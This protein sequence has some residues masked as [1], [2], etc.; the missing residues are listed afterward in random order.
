M[1]AKNFILITFLTLVFFFTARIIG[2][3]FISKTNFWQI[4][5][6][7]NLHHYHLGFALIFI[8]LIFLNKLQEIKDYFLAIGFGM[9][10]DE[11][12][13][14]FK[15]LN[16]GIF[17]HYW[18]SFTSIKFILGTLAQLFVFLIYSFIIIKQKNKNFDKNSRSLIQ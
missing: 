5:I 17:S 9:I 7:D 8:A 18:G 4:L 13:Y 10:I 16:P 11:W 15:F 2:W 6:T 12:F 1:E 3:A 14:I